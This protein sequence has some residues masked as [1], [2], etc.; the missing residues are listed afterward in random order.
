M[1][2]FVLALVLAFC[3][4]PLQ[5]A[6]LERLTLSD[7]VTKS[8][9]VVRGRVLSSTASFSGGLIYTHYQVGVTESLKGH[10]A[11]TVDVAVPGGVAN[12]VRQ[13]I[14]GAPQFKTGDDYVFFLWTSKAG[15]TQVLGL[16]QGLFLVTGTGADPTLARHASHEL[17]LDAST[18]Q[19]VED[20]EMN[21]RLS[22]LRSAIANTLG[23][24]K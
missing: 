6:T 19:P 3:G 2:H 12:G 15:I 24:A 16:T 11:A 13:T 1:R 23:A 22:E 7:M 21:M 8:T 17:M 10:G 14:S 20:R 18:H 9:L 5:S 4:L